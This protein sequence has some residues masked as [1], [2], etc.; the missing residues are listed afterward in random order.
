MGVKPGTRWASGASPDVRLL[1]LERL[2]SK[3]GGE[4]HDTDFW[5]CEVLTGLLKGEVH[6][7]HERH[8]GTLWIEE[9]YV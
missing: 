7:V 8:F 6:N 2:V 4:E 9:E 1:V 5:R 3:L